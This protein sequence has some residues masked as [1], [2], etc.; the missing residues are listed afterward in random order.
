MMNL[1]EREA[2]IDTLKAQLAELD[3]TDPQMQN[4]QGNLL[5]LIEGMKVEAYESLDAYDKV[6]LARH[7]LRPNTKFYI[8]HLFDDFLELHGDRMYADDGAIIGG[9]ALFDGI[10]VT[11]IGHVKGTTVEENIKSNFAMPHPEGY[12]KAMR[13]ALQ[14]EKFKRPIITFIDTPGAFPGIGAEERGQS[15]AIARCLMTFM[16]LKVPVIAVVIGEGGS[17][18]ALAI[19]AA[20]YMIMLEHSVYSVLS[21]E[22]FASIVYKDASRAKEAAAIMKL[23]AADLLEFGV[24]DEIIK[25][26]FGG[27]HEAP[28]YLVPELKKSL[29]EQLAKLM[30]LEANEVAEQR[31]EKFQ[32]I[33]S[34]EL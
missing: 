23:T 21:P 30:K 7:H 14:A 15:E 33:G 12:R 5:E 9:V 3:Q 25:E 19:S 32:R 29:C 34:F 11:V 10:P 4:L 6:Y 22:G 26:P 24:I 13:L 27:A 1:K 16:G 18:G 17:G 31:Y 2:Q 28:D 20:N 8:D